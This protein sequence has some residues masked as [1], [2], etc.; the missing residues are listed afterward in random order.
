VTHYQERLRVPWTWWVV[1]LFFLWVVWL[2]AE[3]IAGVGWATV[4]TAVVAAGVAGLLLAYG[5]VR[6]QVDADGLT[7]GDARLP[8]SAVGEVRP[9]GRDA[10]RALL[11]P[12]ADA[13]A[14]VL[15]RGYVPTAVQ[16]QVVASDDPTPY[17]YVSTRH[18][19]RL[20][21]ALQT[22]RDTLSS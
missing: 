8:L 15:L 3:R 22:A 7:A 18:P 14:H 2:T 13:R 20:A 11:G 5:A 9:L 16:V 4:V 21:A 6:V 19:R 12:R 10:A 1:P 17:W